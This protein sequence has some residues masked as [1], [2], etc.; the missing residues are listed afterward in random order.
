MLRSD[1]SLRRAVEMMCGIR[2]PTHLYAPPQDSHGGEH[3]EPGSRCIPEPQLHA[4]DRKQLV[5][6]AP[7]YGLY[8]ALVS[9]AVA[10]LPRPPML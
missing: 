6:A 7:L 8:G 3:T 10:L 9:A 2:L 4:S 1:L 5:W